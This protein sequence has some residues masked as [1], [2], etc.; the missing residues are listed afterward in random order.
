MPRATHATVSLR[1]IFTNNCHVRPPNAALNFKKIINR[2][3]YDSYLSL[4]NLKII[5]VN[6]ETQIVTMK[7]NIMYISGT[8]KHNLKSIKTA[9]NLRYFYY[10]RYI[11]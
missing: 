1:C 10:I 5:H 11:P 7:C 8:L 4:Y 6:L 9:I 3:Y 2:L